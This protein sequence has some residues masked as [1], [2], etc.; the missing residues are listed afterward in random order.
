[1][2]FRIENAKAINEALER[3][4]KRIDF[5]KTKGHKI[6]KSEFES[7]RR[8]LAKEVKLKTALP[9]AQAKKRI[10][11]GYGR[12]ARHKVG[13]GWA[14]ASLA[15]AKKPAIVHAGR[16]RL[17]EAADGL[18][19]A[20]RLVRGAFLF[21]PRVY[22]GALR[23]VYKR[24]GARLQSINQPKKIDMVVRTVGVVRLRS[25]TRAIISRLLREAR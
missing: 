12:R 3:L 16:V 17:S 9:V 2:S 14:R 10:R 4:S 13:L 18:S 25:T 22:R 21:R 23:R 19:I 7:L 24:V 15:V 11:S 20:G 8:D 5:D 1:M 6:V